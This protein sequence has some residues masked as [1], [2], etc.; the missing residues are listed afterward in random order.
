M[1]HLL[2]EEDVDISLVQAQA[3]ESG[4]FI[5]IASAPKRLRRVKASSRAIPSG[6]RLQP[7]V[8]TLLKTERPPPTPIFSRTAASAAVR[9]TSPKQELHPARRLT[10]PRGMGGK[11]ADF[12]GAEVFRPAAE[13]AA[14]GWGTEVPCIHFNV[15]PS[16]PKATTK[17]WFNV[18][19][20]HRAIIQLPP[21]FNQQGIIVTGTLWRK[22]RE[23]FRRACI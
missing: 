9:N 6:R 13:A 16:M 8:A 14:R 19:N 4:S 5:A 3:S 17:A 11:W 22:L 2:H 12:S 18:R 7:L 20:A 15:G 1:S 21:Q 23:G 10:P